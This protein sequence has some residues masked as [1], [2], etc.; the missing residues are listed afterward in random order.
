MTRG[1]AW[2]ISP[3]FLLSNFKFQAVNG[4]KNL[5]HMSYELFLLK[6]LHFHLLS[7]LSFSRRITDVI[8]YFISCRAAVDSMR[9]ISLEVVIRSALILRSLHPGTFLYHVELERSRIYS[10]PSIS[11]RYSSISGLRILRA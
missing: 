8:V 11:L 9:K 4:Y 6:T 1:E 5:F 10:S 3:K 7:F 2:V